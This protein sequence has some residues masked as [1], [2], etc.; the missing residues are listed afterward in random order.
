[1]RHHGGGIKSERTEMFRKLLFLLLLASSLSAQKVTDIHV[2]DPTI[3]KDKN[4]K[5]SKYSYTD[6]IITFDDKPSYLLFSL[7]NSNSITVI[8]QGFTWQENGETFIDKYGVKSIKTGFTESGAPEITIKTSSENDPNPNFTDRIS[9]NSLILRFCRKS[10]PYISIVN[11]PSRE[12]G[13]F[14]VKVA[15]RCTDHGKRESDTLEYRLS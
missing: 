15:F 13:S 1:M 7:T 5:K 10:E 12:I 3:G 11:Q 4:F 8:V 2:T 14:P 9:G 6:V